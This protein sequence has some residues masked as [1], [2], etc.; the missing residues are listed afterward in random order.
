[1]MIETRGLSKQYRSAVALDGL[2]LAVPEGRI[3]AFLGPNGSGKTTT[4]KI[5]LGLA[6]PTAGE[7]FVF[8]KATTEE[9]SSLEIRQ[10]V[11]YVSED[12]RLYP[13]MTGKQILEFTKPLFPRWSRERERTLVAAFGLRLDQKVKTFSKGMRSKLA[14]ILALARQPDL[15]I[16]DEPSE[17]LD[18]AAAEHMLQAIVQS[19]AEGCTV[20]FSSHQIAEVERIAD[21]V[22]IVCDGRLA[23]H[24]PLEELRENFRRMHCAFIGRAPIEEMSLDGVRKSRANGHVLSLVVDGNIDN[25]TGRA[26]ALGAISVDVQPMNLREIFL[27]AVET[28]TEEQ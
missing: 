25:I 22:S 12:K 17:G 3:S 9:S 16:L 26:R 10:R 20:F 6:R 8:D 2:D 28:G 19:A 7:A 27:D 13:Y 1:M 14:L 5:L 11:G 21:E 24:G 18:P 23:L 15:L 4:I